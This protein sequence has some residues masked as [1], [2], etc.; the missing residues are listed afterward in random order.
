MHRLTRYSLPIVLLCGIILFL[1][2]LGGG[3]LIDDVY[4]LAILERVDRLPNPGPLSLYTFD[5]GDPAALGPVQGRIASWWASADFRMDFFRPLACV[6]H[7][8]D[9]QLYGLNPLGYHATTLALWGLLLL[10]AVWFYRELA[11]DYDQ[12]P[13][14]VLV[15][16]LFFALDDAHA[17]NISWVAHRYALLGALFPLAAMVFYHRFRRTGRIPPLVWSIL[18]CGLGLLSAEGSIALLGWIAAYELCLAK[19]RPAV[20]LRAAAPILVMVLGYLILYRALG[21]GSSGSGFYLDPLSDPL[22]FLWHRI[23]MG[24]PFLLAGALSPVKAEIGLSMITSDAWWPLLLAWGIVLAA[25]LILVPRLRRDRLAL[26]MALAALF[27]LAPR[28]VALPHN[29]MLLLPG[30]GFAWVLGAYVVGAFEPGWVRRSIAVLIVAIHGLAAPVQ[31]VLDTVSIGKHARFE[32]TVAERSQMPGGAEARDARV[33]LVSGPEGGLAIAGQRFLLGYPL[34][35]AVW[36]VS[37]GKGEYR[38]DRTGENSFSLKLISGSILG[39]IGALVYRKDFSFREGERFRQ[40]AMEVTVT[41]VEAGRLRK[42]HVSIDRP[43][44]DPDVWML[45]WDG[46]RYV[47]QRMPPWNPGGAYRDD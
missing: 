22:G 39:G 37:Q 40:G 16:G 45:V 20:R 12:S 38:F 11:R 23:V 24:L 47:R 7:I 35:K 25:S 27:S 36:V 43:L 26:F 17:A 10:V 33:V 30:V 29:R 1:P 32:R 18:L 3:F 34:P 41:G 13:A 6:F 9:H 8:I 19:D 31:A 2:S 14:I 15:A 5:E 42:I 46:S 4:Q 21:Y 44:D 28:L